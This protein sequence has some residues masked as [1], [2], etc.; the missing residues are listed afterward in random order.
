MFYFSKL[1]F[2]YFTALGAMI[3]GRRL[4][5][6]TP[7]ESSADAS[8]Q[9]ES[10]HEFV[11]CV[12]QI[13]AESAKMAMVSPKLASA[14]RLPMWKRFE[15][16]AGRALDLGEWL[17]DSIRRLCVYNMGFFEC[18]MNGGRIQ[19]EHYNCGLQ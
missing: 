14:L 2:N 4:G 17:S 1:S 19:L 15:N 10:I 8:V 3:F 18:F 11:N 7:A 6:V 9:P 5:C 16:A 13:F 12:Q